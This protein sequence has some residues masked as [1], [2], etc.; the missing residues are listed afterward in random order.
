MAKLPT[1]EI[2]GTRIIVVV[3]VAFVYANFVHGF[4]NSD[5][6]WNIVQVRVRDAWL[7]CVLY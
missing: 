7:C 3:Y 1:T 2:I 4:L 5:L 6:A